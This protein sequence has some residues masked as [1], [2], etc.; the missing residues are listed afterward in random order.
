MRTCNTCNETKTLDCFRD[1][2]NKCKICELAANRE[3]HNKNK[4]KISERKKKTYRSE[5]F[6]DKLKEIKNK[7]NETWRNNYKKR[8]SSDPLFRIKLNVKN[9]IRKSFKRYAFTKNSST[10]KI[11][12]CSYEEFKTHLETKFEPWMSWDNYGLYNGTEKYGW[13]IDHIIPLASAETEEDVIRLNHY[14]NLQPL[15]SK[16]N[17][18]IKKGTI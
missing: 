15:C 6:Q 16:V 2:R 9:N 8:Y 5:L 13:D 3:Y 10:F 11:L 17:R 12:G 14:T 7:R 18:D 4:E 1:N